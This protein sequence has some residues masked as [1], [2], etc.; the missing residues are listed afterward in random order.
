MKIPKDIVEKI[1]AQGQREAPNEAC[2]YLA[3]DDGRVV[4][5]IPLTNADHS[6]EHFSLDPKEQFAAVRQLRGEGL[7]ILAVYHTHPATPARPSAEDIRLAYDPS[8]LY[9]IASLQQGKPDIRAFRIR[10]GEVTNETLVVED[11]TMLAYRIP[12]TYAREIDDLEALVDRFRAGTV[13]EAELKARRVPFGVYEQRT[14][15]HFMIRIRCAAGIVTPGQLRC[16]ANLASQFGSGRLHITTRQEIQMH[17]VPLESIVPVIRELSA[18]GLATRGGGGNTVRNIIASWDS[19]IAVDEVFDVTPHAVELTSRLIALGDSWLLPRKFKIAFSNSASDNAFATANDVGFIA[20]VN[21]NRQGFRVFVA[22][23]MGRM[24]QAGQL[25]HEFVAEDEVLLV[26]EAVKRLF[27]KRG[28]RRNK[29]SARLRFLWNTLGRPHFLEEYQSQRTALEAEH[30]APFVPPVWSDTAHAPSELV[31][32]DEAPPD[33]D[34]WKERYVTTQ[35]QSGQYSI[36]VPLP[37]GDLPSEEAALLADSLAPFGDNTIRCTP[38]QNISLRNIPDR[39][40]G[41]IFKLVCQVSASW[42][43]PKLVANAV[44]CAGASTCQLGICLS[45]GALSATLDRLKD[46][47]IDLDGLGDFRLHFSGCSNSCGRHGLAHLGFFG[48]AGHRGPHSYPAYVIVAGATIDAVHG[49]ALARRIDDISAHDV[50]QFVAEFLRHYAVRKESFASF[51]DYLAKEGEAQI[52]AICDQY[53]HVPTLEE[54]PSYYRDWGAQELFSLA[55]RGTGE[56]AAGLFDLI[57]VDLA[58]VRADRSTFETENDPV[59]R[60]ALLYRLVVTAARALLITRGVE[61]ATDNDVLDRFEHS[62]VD[63][64]I[65]AEGSRAVIGAA[66]SGAQTLVD[67]SDRALAFSQEVEDLYLSMDDTLQFH[68]SASQKGGEN[69]R[70]EPTKI[71][72]VRDLR[73]V[74]CPMNFVKTKVALSQLRTGQVLQVLLDEGE[75][76]ENVPRS[77]A[78]EGHHILEQARVAEHWSVTIRKA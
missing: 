76:I 4:K 34:L 67:I 9:V 52:R 69:G 17:D 13:T 10:Q 30:P 27:S 16:V 45:R 48:K 66:R 3:G 43:S 22:G 28:N 63:A 5:T 57:E 6:P 64:G 44:A 15:G 58:K 21:G 74:A 51:Q 54:D 72:L 41:N 20:A 59:V 56:C 24:P 40:L 65:V 36:L 8:I 47:D 37:L 18:V 19:G 77:V 71:D 78:A 26:A 55:G 49:S 39:Y 2:G 35:R 7:Q 68:P 75:P 50:P 38:D 29:H 11:R 62:F 31:A 1:F 23:G 32:A 70:K 14:K 73:G 42:N 25:L 12:E 60:A 33:F 61:A 53:R 46:S